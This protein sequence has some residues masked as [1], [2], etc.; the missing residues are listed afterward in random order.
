MKTVAVAPASP[1]LTDTSFTA[2]EGGT[3]SLTMVPMPVVS[4]TV[5]PVGELSITLN[6]SVASTMVSPATV[7]FTVLEASPGP[8]LRVVMGIAV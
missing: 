3:S 5:A 1:S 7:T 4:D 8:K 2:R 6:V